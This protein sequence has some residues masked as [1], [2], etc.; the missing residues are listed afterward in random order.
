MSINSAEVKIVVDLTKPLPK[1]LELERENG[2]V[3][4]LQVSYPWL[5]PLSLLCNTIGHKEALFPDAPPP[6]KTAPK[7]K[8]VDN[9]PIPPKKGFSLVSKQIWKPVSTVIPPSS[10]TQDSL[11][12]LPIDSSEKVTAQSD[13]GSDPSPLLNPPSTISDPVTASTIPESHQV[14]SYP[15]PKS[16]PTP[17]D[18]APPFVPATHTVHVSTVAM[19][20]HRPPPI[21]NSFAVLQEEDTTIVLIDKSPPPNLVGSSPSSSDSSITC[22]IT[23]EDGTEFIYTA[24]YAANEEEERRHLWTSLRDTEAAFGLSS[25][26]WLINGD[27]NEIF[28]PAETSNVNIVSSTRGMRLFGACLADLGVF[29]L[30]SRG[31]L[32]TWTNK[33]S[34]DPIGK[35]LD[36]AFRFFNLLTRQP[37]FLDTVK[38]AWDEVDIQIRLLKDFCFKLRRIKG[39]LK[40]LM[41]DN[42]SDIEK[43]VHEAYSELCHFQILAL[44]DPSPLNVQN[45]LSA[46]DKWSRLCLAE[47]SFFSQRSRL[48]WIGEGDSNTTFFHS[49][50]MARNACNAVKVL[51]KPD[52]SLTSSLQEVH[53]I[54]VDYF[55][56][57]LTTIRGQFCPALPEFLD[58]L[59]LPVCSNA[60]QAFLSSPFSAEDIKAYLFKMP[61][62]RSP[63]PDGFPAEFFK[64]TWPIIGHDLTL[65]VLQF[66][67]DSFMPKA[68]NATSL[69]LIPKRVG[70]VDLKEFRPI[71]CLNTVYKIISR[72]LT[73]KLKMLMPALILPNQTAFVKDKL[74]LENALLASEVIKGYHSIGNTA[75]ITLKVEISKAFDS[76]RWDFLLSTLQAHNILSSFMNWIRACVCSPAFMISLN[77]VTTGYFKGKTGLCQDDP[78]SP[79]L[80]VVVMNVLSA[81]LN[82]AAENGH[83]QYHPGCEDVKLT[84]LFF[85]DD[86]LIFLEGSM[87]SLRG[88]MTILETF[89]KLSGLG[90]NIVKTSMFCSELSDDTL[91][92]ISSTFN[93]TPSPLPIR[94]L[95]LPLCSRKLSVKDCDPLLSKIR[96]KMNSWTHMFLSLDGRLILLSTVIS[97]IINFWTSAFFLPKQVIKKINSL[98][99]S[100][101]WHG[102][103]H[104]STGAK[105]SWFDICFPKVEGGL[106]LRQ[107]E[108]L[109]EACAM[110]LIWMLY[111][112]A[113][114]IWVAWIRSRY[115][116]TSPLWALNE[117][118]NAYSWNFR[119]LLKLRPKALKFL[120]IKIGNGDT[121]LFWWDPWTPFGPLYHYLTSDGPSRLGIPLFASV[122]DLANG[123][124]WT[125]P[126]A[127][128]ERQVLLLSYISSISLSSAID[129][130]TWSIDGGPSQVILLQSCVEFS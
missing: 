40:A 78:L 80:F 86:L 119:K 130:P 100:F 120:N 57:A 95:G 20:A 82:K 71:A 3:L 17:E 105:V 115:L 44:N 55:S 34:S 109:N 8:K 91:D 68:L 127:R 2:Q 97:G 48:R 94:Y 74:L 128:S 108:S 43:R 123:E 79:I 11:N 67:Q 85:A 14:I 35:K 42:Y 129:S 37:L 32:Y 73:D 28:T 46:K 36:R 76:V 83:F 114:S 88:V 66:F 96:M 27:F 50:T 31:H 29:D 41:K 33:R 126:H 30:P 69:I 1:S 125:L 24:V 102:K 72:P 87:D 113:G 118:N 75:R 16:S 25:R 19:L 84:H 23:L 6:D 9:P 92:Q 81:M 22:E 52:G 110:K 77:G 56:K 93:L 121:T 51:L 62:N 104:V 47:E 60:Q 45:E 124:G 90:M 10:A 5:P 59:L 70:A 53:E 65:Y 101:L 12:T 99:S 7:G 112:K 64:A 38:K 98:C 61:L 89:E 103:I 111:F 26:P 49:V 15:D 18:A 39:P 63:G 106:G 21:S 122:S 116:S 4:V 107:I 54:A 13:P 117:K 58:A